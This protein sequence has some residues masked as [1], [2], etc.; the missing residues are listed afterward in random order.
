MSSLSTGTRLVSRFATGDL[1][2]TLVTGMDYAWIDT[3]LLYAMGDAPSIDRYAPN[4]HQSVDRP[5]TPLADEDGLE[6][7]SGLCR[8]R[9]NSTNGVCRPGYAVTGSR[10]VDPT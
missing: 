4:Y 1:Q 5:T 3:S 7:R 9:S 2:H 10:F 6:H 8:I